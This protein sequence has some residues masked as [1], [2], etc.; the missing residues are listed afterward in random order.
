M[1]DSYMRVL[2]AV[3]LSILFLGACSN[4]EQI[5]PQAPPPAAYSYDPVPVEDYWAKDNFDLQRAGQ[6]LER[7]DTP[8]R[9]ERYIN[10]PNGINNL[11]LNGDGYVDYI[12][13]DEFE[14]RDDLFLSRPPSLSWSAS[15]RGR[16]RSAVRGQ[17]LLRDKLARPPFADRVD[18]IQRSPGVL[19]LALLLR[20]LPRVVRHVHGR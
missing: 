19:S 16:K 10:E 1:E 4:D 8:E 14:D 9:F 2:V 7:S 11:D 5:L 3:F 18:A 6:F 15:P 17:F 20:Q 13:V 12:S